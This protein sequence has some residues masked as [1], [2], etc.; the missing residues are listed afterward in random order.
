MVINVK[1]TISLILLLFIFK[2]R[3][4]TGINVLNIPLWVIILGLLILIKTFSKEFC[5]SKSYTLLSIPALSLITIDFIT[6]GR[7]DYSYPL[8]KTLLII[9]LLGFLFHKQSFKQALGG[10]SFITVLLTIEFFWFF[11]NLYQ[12]I[13]IGRDFYDLT[14]LTINSQMSSSYL[15]VGL[16]IMNLSKNKK[17]DFKRSVLNIF[18]IIFSLGVL[19]LSNSRT[20]LIIGLIPLLYFFIRK[21]NWTLKVGLFCLVLLFTYLV[22][23]IFF[24]DKYIEKWGRFNTTKEEDLTT[25]RSFIWINV[26][27]NV[28]DHTLYGMGIGGATFGFLTHNF[29]TP[30]AHNIILQILGDYGVIGAVIFLM[31]YLFTLKRMKKLI[32]NK[33]LYQIILI[34]F[35]LMSLFK[36]D[37]YILI[38]FLVFIYYETT[39]FKH[40]HS[41]VREIK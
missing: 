6:R 13:I 11:T 21:A 41:M 9:I 33:I 38:L 14:F 16:G 39:N 32:H 40:N 18:L 19:I 31:L 37:N 34:Q 15:S 28:K 25:G 35:S 29:I 24:N 26:L 7:Y 27:N 20:Y 36:A 10:N 3:F 12:F 23:D 4:F 17:S 2:F 1:N 30:R 8:F 5:F 22:K